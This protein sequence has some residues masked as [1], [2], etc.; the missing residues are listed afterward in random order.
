MVEVARLVGLKPH[1]RP[2]AGTDRRIAAG[3]AGR[4]G[5]A[6]P[7]SRTASRCGR[8]PRWPRSWIWPPTTTW[9]CPN[10][11]TSSKAAFRRFA[12]GVPGHRFTP[13]HRR[14]RATP[15][16]RVRA[17]R[18]R[19]R[20]RGSGVLLGIHRQ[21]R[22]RRRPLGPGFAAGVRR[23]FARVAGGRLPAVAGP[24]GGDAAP[25]RRRRCPRRSAAKVVWCSGPW[26][27]API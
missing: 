26:Q 20:R 9:V 13:G 16:I 12:P 2:C 15:G 8:A 6:A 14:H 11:P 1:E 22:G 19:R 4:G 5:E 7:P 10:I 21:S 27:C 25:R 23:P 18:I 3:V 17:R 24:G